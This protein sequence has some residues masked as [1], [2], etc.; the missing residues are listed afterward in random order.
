MGVRLYAEE[1]EREGVHLQ[2]RRERESTRKR[3]C[4]VQGR[5]NEVQRI[6]LAEIVMVIAFLGSDVRG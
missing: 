3:V 6:L 4:P 1:R 5:S 2:V